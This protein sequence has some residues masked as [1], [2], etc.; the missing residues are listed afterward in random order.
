MALKIGISKLYEWK[1]TN[2]YFDNL[3]LLYFKGCVKI[4]TKKFN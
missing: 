3:L 1:D 4:L 2:T